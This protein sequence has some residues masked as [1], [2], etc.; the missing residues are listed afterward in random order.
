MISINKTIL[1]LLL[2]LTVNLYAQG[3]AVQFDGT[4]DYAD[5]DDGIT[6]SLTGSY[7]IETWVNMSSVSSWM[8]IFDF[9]AGTS[10][11][12][13]LTPRASN[14]YVRFAITTNGGANEQQIN[15]TTTFPLN[16][17]VHVAITYNQSSTT[18][19]LY[20]NG[21]VA[22]TN[23]SMT[24]KPSDLGLTTQNYLAKSQY[25][26]PYL[27][28]KIDEFRIWSEALS[29][30]TIERWKNTYINSNH[31]NFGNLITYLKMNEGSGSTL[32]DE[33]GNFDALLI[34][35]PL[36]V[37]SNYDFKVGEWSISSSENN[38]VQQNIGNITPKVQLVQD[39]KGGVI[40][41]WKDFS[42]NYR[43][44]A[45]RIDKNGLPLWNKDGIVIDENLGGSGTIFYIAPSEDSGLLVGY[46]KGTFDDNYSQKLDSNGILLWGAGIN[47]QGSILYSVGI[48]S[49]GNGGAIFVWDTY[50]NSS[51]NDIYAQ[52]IYSNG[53]KAWGNFIIVC[54]QEDLQLFPEIVP[55]GNGGVIIVWLDRRDT[56]LRTALYAQRL[57]SSGAW[58]WGAAESGT[59]VVSW[60]LNLGYIPTL[61]H[62]LS[63]DNNGNVFLTWTSYFDGS[64]N[65]SNIGI[66]KIFS[67]GTFGGNSTFVTT[68]ANNQ[69][70]PQVAVS[71]SN[72]FVVWQDYRS[73][74]TTGADI[75]L[76]R[77][78]HDLNALGGNVIVCNEI[79]DQTFPMISE[80]GNGGVFIVWQDNRSGQNDIYMQHINSNG[81][82]SWNANGIVVS[83]NL[84]NQISPVLV[85][86]IDGSA[87]TAW[88]DDR[89]SQ[90]G[91]YASKVF[92]DGALPVELSA[93]NASIIE[94][95][96]QLNWQ[97]AT[98][99]NNYGFEIE[100]AN[101]GTSLDL[102]LHWETIGFVEGHGNSNS[103]KEYSFIDESVH[104]GTFSYRLK[105]I[106]IDGNFEYS[107]IISVETHR[108][109]SLPTEFALEQNY[110]NP[111]NP[112]TSIEYSVQSSEFVSLKVYD[113]LGT[114][115]ATLVNEK[116]EAGKYRVNFDASILSSGLYI[117]KIQAGSFNQ[118]RKMMLLK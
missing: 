82:A 13:F 73:T 51:N 8:R 36:F 94:N 68:A 43:L 2:F 62:K 30:I 63:H 79:G 93:F 106:D 69:N 85:S 117:Y 65:P 10:T 6:Q 44:K 91:I 58:Q 27:N 23:T 3:Y 14:G 17:W 45:Q 64:S 52:R 100:R 39:G 16:E 7:T 84:S 116:K 88:G 96:V 19:T 54:G 76:Q 12:M 77:Y 109:V 33:E 112:A 70:N 75:Y 28:G 114:E 32:N 101:A 87:I 81:T 60:S 118:V 29:Q 95:G 34:D 104:N 59:E 53:I 72:V 26:D 89:N 56:N 105:Q 80:D 55:D 4:N 83:D 31:P 22:G 37:V 102:S 67:D 86:S 103:P 57:N 108:G 18:G 90:Y 48:V 66:R 50:L 49:D 46:E 35:S 42:T 20:V 25:A 113:I 71:G 1:I 98:E 11:Y 78:D 99:V 40:L 110:P 38:S 15:T 97:T 41:V 107:E 21:Q 111:F 9:G 61:Q 74:A 47:N 5:I 115:V 92:N 24:I